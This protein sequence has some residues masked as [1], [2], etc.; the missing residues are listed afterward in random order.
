MS[1]ISNDVRIGAFFDLDLTITAKD[2]FRHFLKRY[3]L[4]EYFN[5]HFIPHVFICGLMRKVRFV[6]LQT[7]KEK[8]LVFLKG[9]EK[10]FIRQVGKSFFEKNLLGILRKKAI[11]R[12]EWHRLKGHLVFIVSSSPDIYL[13]HLVQ[14]LKCDGYECTKLAYREDQFI[15][16]FEG[17]DCFGSEKVEKMKVIA[18]NEQLDLGGSFAYSDHESDVPMLGLVGNPVVISPTAKLKKIAEENRWKI[19]KW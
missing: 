16:R 19:E 6:S 17:K 5:W 4:D 9:K 1:V 8:A 15:C 2:S 11:E 13:F 12:I 18:A 10:D 14:Y 3:Y 7:F